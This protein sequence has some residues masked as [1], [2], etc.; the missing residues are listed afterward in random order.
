MTETQDRIAALITD[1]GNDVKTVGKAEAAT[2]EKIESGLGFSL[3]DSYKWFLAEYGVLMLPTYIIYGAGSPDEPACLKLTLGLRESKLPA[4]YVVVENDNDGRIIC[5]DAGRMKDGE[6][7]V[8][9][10][11]VQDGSVKDLYKDFYELLEAKLK[12]TLLGKQARVG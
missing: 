7:P 2:I 11:G 4:A 5:L 8:V 9:S 3:P 10:W 1:L 12:D 6:C